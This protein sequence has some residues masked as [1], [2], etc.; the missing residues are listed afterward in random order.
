MKLCLVFILVFVGAAL[1][2][3]EKR[4][5]GSVKCDKLR[6]Y[7]VEIVS[8]QRKARCGGSLLNTLWVITAA[9]CG[10]QHLEVELGVNY[11][12]PF[13]SKIKG[14][15]KSDKQKIEPKQQF[16]FKDEEG[17]LHDIMLIKLTKAVKAQYPMVALP[18]E[19]CT[20]PEINKQ[21]KVGGFGTGSSKKKF[22]A[23]LMCAT[24]EMSTCGENDKP[25]SKYHSDESTTMCAHKP[26]VDACYGD[27]G[28]GVEYDNALYGII[29]SDPVDK[30]T[31]QIVML[32]I[33]HYREWIG[34]TMKENS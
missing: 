24:T 31:N 21:V 6:Q 13:F 18:P 12:K 27:A 34:K 22:F 29:V 11:D 23:K 8:K 15:F 32:N 30:C 25:D 16:V 19:G 5:L 1:S 14:F 2:A 28:S 17:H 4:I 7:H 33:C 26:G 10:E 3:I 9:H 20:K